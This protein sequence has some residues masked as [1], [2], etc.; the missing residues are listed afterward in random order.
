MTTILDFVIK[1]YKSE[2]I[3]INLYIKL[4]SD[5]FLNASYEGK[6]SDLDKKISEIL[7]ENKIS[8][9]EPAVNR[10]GSGDPDLIRKYKQL[11]DDGIITQEEF[12]AKKKE[13][14]GL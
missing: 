1:H 9:Y 4:E 11:C 2:R 14:L 12:Q 7:I 8:S 6:A 10:L 3:N 5:K 13:I